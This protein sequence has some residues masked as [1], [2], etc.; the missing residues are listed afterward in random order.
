[1]VDYQYPDGALV[2]ET[3]GYGTSGASTEYFDLDPTSG[4]PEVTQDGVGHQGS[5]TLTSSANPMTAGDVTL[6]TDAVGNT[7]AYAY[8]SFNQVWCTVNPAEY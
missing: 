3:T 1:M 6:S 4:V 7:T 2:A 8:N 5:A